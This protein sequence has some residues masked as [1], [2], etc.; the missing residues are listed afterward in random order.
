MS[1]S[2]MVALTDL[3]KAVQLR[4][5]EHDAAGTSGTTAEQPESGTRLVDAVCTETAREKFLAPARASSRYAERPVPTFAAIEA[6]AGSCALV[7]KSGEV[8]AVF[9]RA[10]Y[11]MFDARDMQKADPRD[12]AVVSCETGGALYHF[13]AGKKRRAQ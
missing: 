12:L 10:G 2:T 7:A 13:R 3:R 1:T 8:L 6:P 9:F 5:T 4:S 11:S